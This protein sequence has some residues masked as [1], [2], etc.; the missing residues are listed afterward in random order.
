LWRGLAEI[1]DSAED[2]RGLGSNTGLHS[3][4]AVQHSSESAHQ[5]RLRALDGASGADP[6]DDCWNR[7]SIAAQS[8]IFQ[9]HVSQPRVITR[10]RLKDAGSS[11]QQN[12]WQ[13]P[14]HCSSEFH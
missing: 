7:V 10:L 2:N 12:E 5:F 8:L 1:R 13:S 3:Q 9:L 14:S 11:K 4:V 6:D